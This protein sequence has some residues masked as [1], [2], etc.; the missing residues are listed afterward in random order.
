MG[1]FAAHDTL[2]P[3]AQDPEHRLLRELAGAHVFHKC[4]EN[5]YRFVQYFRRAAE[6]ILIPLPILNFMLNG[7]VYSAVFANVLDEAKL[8]AVMKYCIPVVN[9]CFTLIILNLGAPGSPA[10]P[11]PCK[12]TWV[13]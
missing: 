10:P 12:N 3:C 6:E 9:A 8:E 5:L 2:I 13:W 7:M 1:A 11:P 4:V